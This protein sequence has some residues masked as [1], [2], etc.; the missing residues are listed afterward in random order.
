MTSRSPES[1]SWNLAAFALAVS[2]LALAAA[3]VHVG[4]RLG[5]LARLD[6]SV[7]AGDLVDAVT[8]AGLPAPRL[9]PE[10]PLLARRTIVVTEGINERTAREV[11]QK[12]LYLDA[13]EPGRD[14]HLV[15]ASPGGWLDAAFTIVDAMET[16]RSRVDTT[17][18]GGCYS[19]GSVILAAGTGRRRVS[20]NAL[21]MV[22]ANREDSS[23]PFSFGR[24]SL[25]R[26][27]RFYREHASLPGEWFP[28]TGSKTY[29]LSPEEAVRYGLAD[30]I[31]EP[32]HPE[33]GRKE[34][35]GPDP[36]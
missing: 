25:A 7:L 29:Y 13:R 3:L 15:L 12:L 10:D 33:S 19:A 23:E 17:C 22:H 26:F 34:P 11:V 1:R 28:L 2:L 24:L 20:R 8:E 36:G 4:S 31:I 21:V 9:D 32:R 30:E 16:I 6:T 18:V 35:P 27:D 5:E 14:I